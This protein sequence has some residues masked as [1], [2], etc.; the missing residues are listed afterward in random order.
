MIIP[1]FGM[2]SHVISTFSGKPVFGYFKLSSPYHINFH[3]V[4]DIATY[5]MREGHKLFNNTN[6][7]KL[8]YMLVI[9]V[10]ICLKLY[11]PQV[12][13]TCNNYTFAC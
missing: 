2:I 11:N 5:Y 9:L 10:I 8:T 1:G 12:T 13:N 6:N 4:Y 3:R 7:I